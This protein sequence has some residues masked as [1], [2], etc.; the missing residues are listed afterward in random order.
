MTDGEQA[1]SRLRERDYAV[2]VSDMR[3]PKVDGMEMLAWIGTHRPEM[4]PRILFIT[5]DSAAERND[6]A[7]RAGARLLLKPFKIDDLT[8]VCR[9][10]IESW[11]PAG[12]N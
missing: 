9:T 12:Q 11:D 3:M 7:V 1:I 5:G 6:A 10:I 2:V 4:V 8:R